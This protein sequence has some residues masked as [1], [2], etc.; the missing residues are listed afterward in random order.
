MRF[1]SNTKA[2]RQTPPAASKRNSFIFAW[3]E[4]LSVSTRGLPSAVQT[5]QQQGMTRNSFRTSSQ[6]L[7]RVRSPH[8]I[9]LPTSLF[10]VC[11]TDHMLLRTYCALELFHQASEAQE[12]ACRA[13]IIL[14]GCKPAETGFL[15]PRNLL[16][17]FTGSSK[18]LAQNGVRR[19]CC[20]DVLSR[21][22]DPAPRSSLA[23][24]CR[25][26]L[27]NKRPSVSNSS[28][29]KS[30]QNLTNFLQFVNKLHPG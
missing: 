24:P 15:Q 13:G 28:C 29:V 7:I 17:T 23:P 2:T 16:V 11:H 14:T 8:G 12:E 10:I 5:L 18:E 27:I 26:I 30:S 3:R 1:G 20:S 9:R 6:R 22:D 4:P 19:P 25:P 21:E